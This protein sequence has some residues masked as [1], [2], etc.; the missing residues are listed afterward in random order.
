MNAILT[1]GI[2]IFMINIMHGHPVI[3][4]GGHVISTTRSNQTMEIKAHKSISKTISFGLHG[5]EFHD[6]HMIMAQANTLIKRW[7]ET[8]AQSNAYLFTGMGIKSNSTKSYIGGH[9][10]GQIDWE[11]RRYYSQFN[12]DG[13]LSNDQNHIIKT[14]VGIAPY[15]TSY[16]N[17]HAWLIIQ[18]STHKRG[19]QN[20]SKI[21]PVIRLFK[22]NILV[23]I[24]TD[25]SNQHL[26]TGMIHF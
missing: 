22:K 11:T 6:S 17:I 2:I 8:N 10:G 24:G 3:W 15:L 7:N 21:L 1:M 14:R 19:N 26:M 12:Y 25:F 20:I 13:F 9:V 18:W 16:E 4:K 5:I 23:E